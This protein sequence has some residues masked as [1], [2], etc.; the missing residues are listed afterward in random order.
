MKH[1]PNRNPP[2]FILALII[3][4]V[5]ALSACGNGDEEP[6]ATPMSQ[7]DAGDSRSVLSADGSSLTEVIPAEKA[8]EIPDEVPEELAVIWEAWTLLTK[9]HV[10]K[11]NL[12]PAALSE[13]AV[14]G[15]LAAVEDPHTYYVS[16]KAFA[17]DTQDILLG[18]F[19]G[20]GAHVQ[21]NRAGKLIISSPIPGGPAEGAGLRPGDIVVTVNGESIE[22]LSL[23]EAVA[24]IR[25]PEG[26]VVTLGILHIGAI[27]PVAIEVRR[28]KIP[29]ESVLLRSEPGARFVHIRLTNFF[30]QTAEELGKM[31]EN[32]VDDGAD[33]LILDVRGNLGGLLTSVVD[34][35]SQFLSDGLVLYEI[36]GDGN[37]KNWKVRGGG[38]AAE[39]PM[40]LLVNQFSASASEVLA[41]ALQDH[42]RATIVGATTFGKGVAGIFKS[43]TNGGGV[44]ITTSRWFTPQDRAIQGVGVEPDVE[45]VARD[46]RDADVMQLE[47]AIQVL[48]SEVTRTAG[49]SPG[50]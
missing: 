16:P 2:L 22:G 29:L 23:P 1:L 3:A 45:V 21:M 9:H 30:P 38:A 12:D 28:R 47:K 27:D 17:I 49:G 19:E 32:A 44:A 39:I 31:I 4:G 35:A 34:V 24:L 15:M 50:S 6:A 40:V 8:L 7:G 48:E 46:P 41:G 43:L 20:I 10:D 26:T 37:R 13:A 33:G 14:K 5:L 36:D 11:G 42:E 25:G 18:R